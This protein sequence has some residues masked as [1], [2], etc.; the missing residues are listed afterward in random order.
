MFDMDIPTRIWHRKKALTPGLRIVVGACE[1]HATMAKETLRLDG[2]MA[3]TS[4][5]QEI[6]YG[7]GCLLQM[8]PTGVSPDTELP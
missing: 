3:R 7:D 1:Q 4:I 5:D 2:D 6:V 8:E